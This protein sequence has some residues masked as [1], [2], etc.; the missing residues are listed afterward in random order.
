LKLFI[1]TVAEKF[2]CDL[3]LCEK[4]GAEAPLAESPNCATK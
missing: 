2:F 3:F 1:L 4:S